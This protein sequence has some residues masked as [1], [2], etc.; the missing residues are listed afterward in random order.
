[1]GCNDTIIFRQCLPH[2]GMAY[3]EENVRLFNYWDIVKRIDN[4]FIPII[5]S[6]KQLIVKEME[7]KGV[8]VP[9]NKY[10]ENLFFLISKSY[11]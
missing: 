6:E 3:G 11:L 2:H 8:F 5:M 10:T 9:K 1:M 4:A 7:K